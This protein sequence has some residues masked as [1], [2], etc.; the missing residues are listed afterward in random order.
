VA[1][2]KAYINKVVVLEKGAKK[3]AKG[4]ERE[5]NDPVDPV[6]QAKARKMRKRPDDIDDGK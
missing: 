3:K 6:T 5:A 4:R 1:E 2:K